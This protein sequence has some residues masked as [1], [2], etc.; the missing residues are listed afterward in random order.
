MK[1]SLPEDAYNQI[2]DAYA[3]ITDKKPHNAYYERPATK[4]LI[5]EVKNK[6]IADIGCGTGAYISWLLDRGAKVV[7]VDANDKMLSYAKERVGNKAELHLA[8]MEEPLNF[9][10]GNYFDGIISALAIAYVRDYKSLFSEFRRILKKNGWFVFSTEHPFFSYRYFNISDYFENQEVS[11]EWT[12]FGDTVR[13]KSYYHSLGS[14]TEA[15]SMN[16]FAIE[17]ILEPKPISEFEKVSPNDY[18]ELMHFPL[19][20]CIRARKT[21]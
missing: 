6:L 18:Q 1:P 5:G 21:N 14:I 3:A 19:F 13:M 20:I 10:Q 11:C 15:L 4:S 17:R 16:G 7:G 8:N 2:A 9:L 12:G